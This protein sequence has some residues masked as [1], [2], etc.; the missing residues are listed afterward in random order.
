MFVELFQISLS[1]EDNKPIKI[2]YATIKEG[3]YETYENATYGIKFEYSR[4]WLEREQSE[5]GI[6]DH[7][8]DSSFDIAILEYLDNIDSTVDPII[9]ISVDGLPENI[10]L[11]EYRDQVADSAKQE[12]PNPKVTYSS[13]KPSSLL[14]RPTYEY[15]FS[16]TFTP[17][18]NNSYIWMDF[19]RTNIR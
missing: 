8:I 5:A 10:T 6:Q 19:D 17:N 15:S 11:K 18:N 4:Y 2:S 16:V 12:I 14:G 9:W 13:V 7:G 3:D 1:Q